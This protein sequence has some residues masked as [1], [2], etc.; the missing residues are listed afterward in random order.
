[1][2]SPREDARTACLFWLKRRERE[3]VRREKQRETWRE[4]EKA[5]ARK[6]ARERARE[7][8]GGE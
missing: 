7:S 5:R 4:G 8:E 2:K 3:N 1:M 6:K